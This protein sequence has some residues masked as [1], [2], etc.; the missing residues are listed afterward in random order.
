MVDGKGIINISSPEYLFA[1]VEENDRKKV[2]AYVLAWKVAVNNQWGQDKEHLVAF[3]HERGKYTKVVY[4]IDGEIIGNL[5]E[6]DDTVTTGLDSFAIVPIHNVVT[7]DSIYGIDDYDDV[8]SIV[9]E[10]EIRTAQISKILDVHANP[11]VSGSQNALT[12]DKA[13]GEYYFDAGNYYAR[14]S[15]EE[16]SL[17]YI[18]WEA[19][20]DAN[21]KQIER[22]L[23]HLSVIS[24]MG[25]AIFDGELKTGNL[26]SGS[27]LK[28]LYINA[29]AKVA[30]VRNAFD[31]G[32]KKAIAIA[33][34]IGYDEVL[35]VEDISI[36]W[37]DG[38]PNDPK[39][40]AE[41]ISIRTAGTQTMSAKRAMVEYDGMSEEQASEEIKTLF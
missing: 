13:T 11:T 10:L 16:P 41:I 34:Q 9:S 40:M 24:E 28:R 14:T 33:S 20:L 1:C 30:R 8:D 23:N 27:A 7:S 29:L 37:Q 2:S 18:T 31:M 21:F 38:L 32:L 17:E 26:P 19:S 12:Y 22:L 39:E 3:V 35:S 15:N 36:M 6:E 5:V 25:A 4:E